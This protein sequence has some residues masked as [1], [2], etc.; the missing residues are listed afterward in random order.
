MEKH[1]ELLQQ[2]QVY[3]NKDKQR[4]AETF[5]RGE[6][7]NVFN[8]L[9]VDNMELSHSVFLAALLAPMAATVYRTHS[10]KPLL[11]SSHTA[12]PNPN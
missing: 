2:L 4:R 8:V 11:T 5:R 10:Q 6:C 12:A 3:V 7:Y 9:G 1:T